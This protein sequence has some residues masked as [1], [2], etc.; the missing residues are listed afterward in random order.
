MILYFDDMNKSINVNQNSFLGRTVIWRQTG[1]D[2]NK[3]S[4]PSYYTTR[5]VDKMG[6]LFHK[7]FITHIL[8]TFF[9]I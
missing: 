3:A 4:I 5:A 2:K 7:E 6:D 9:F 8:W 1:I